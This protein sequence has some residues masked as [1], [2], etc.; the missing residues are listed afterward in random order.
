MNGNDRV[1]TPEA[2]APKT[3]FYWLRTGSEWL[4][5]SP[6]ERN[7]FVDSALRPILRRYPQVKLRY[8]DAEAYSAEVSDVLAWEFHTDSAYAAVVECLRETRFWNHYFE[9]IK[10]IPC[11]ED[12]FASHYGVAGFKEKAPASGAPEP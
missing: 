4:K 7:A 8:F 12:G 11:V 10:I 1:M 5:L 6:A 9:V 2:G 3:V